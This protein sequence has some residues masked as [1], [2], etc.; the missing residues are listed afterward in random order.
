LNFNKVYYTEMGIALNHLLYGLRPNL[1]RASL[2]EP[3]SLTT[4][5]CDWNAGIIP[6]FPGPDRIQIVANYKLFDNLIHQ[7]RVSM[8]ESR[9]GGPSFHLAAQR[10]QLQKNTTFQ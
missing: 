6:L 1:S 4:R 10:Q 2:R 3:Q 9:Q 8:A 5:S 7:K